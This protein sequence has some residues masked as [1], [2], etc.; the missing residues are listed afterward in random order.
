M[1]YLQQFCPVPPKW[2]VQILIDVFLL[3]S[4]IRNSIGLM[5][6]SVLHCRLKIIF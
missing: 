1:S 6:S 3:F 4:Y 2:V 5:I